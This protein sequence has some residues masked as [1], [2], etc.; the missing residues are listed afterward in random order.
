MRRAGL[1]FLGRRGG[2]IAAALGAVVLMGTAESVTAQSL[3]EALAKT[4]ANNPTLLAQRANLRAIDEEVPQALSNWRPTVTF[5][6][7][8]GKTNVETTSQP[9]TGTDTTT[10]GENRTPRSYT[11]SLSQPL[12]RGFRTVAETRRAENRVRAERARLTAT[13]QTVLRDGVTAYMDVVRDQAV[14]ELNISNEQV[15]R[16]QLEAANDRFEVGEITRTD[17]SQA[18]ARLARATADRVQAEGT[19]ESSRAT[20][21]RVIGELP[22]SLSEPEPPT[23]LPASREEVI[24]QT[25]GANPNIIAAISDERAARDNVDLVLGELLPTVSL[26][27]ELSRT[28]DTIGRSSQIDTGEVLATVTVPLYQAGDVSARVRVAKQLAS[29]RRIQIEEVRRENIEDAIQAWADLT[30]AREQVRSFEKETDAN[31]IALEGTEQEATAGLRTVLDILD[32]EQELLDARVSLVRARR[33]V[34]VTAYR[35]LE[36]VGRL[37]AAD[38]GLAVEFY[39]PMRHYDEV[40]DLLFGLDASGE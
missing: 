1:F 18:E 25:A 36:S 7:D 30:S 16:R 15:L 35:V 4:Y 14:L 13:E 24:A 40:R 2:T 20:Y 28:E 17:V 5:T 23:D 21:Q 3:E 9:T 19:L 39:D 10:N 29:R 32:A 38:L 11:L 8:G 26:T 12:F 34:V 31:K 6:A 22:Q 27:G 33:D 37:T